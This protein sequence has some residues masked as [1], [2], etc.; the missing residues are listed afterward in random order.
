MTYLWT[1]MVVT[2]GAGPFD[3]FNT[4]IPYPNKYVC[5]EHIS[6]T[7]AQLVAD[8]LAVQMIRCI[9]TDLLSRTV[10]PRPRPKN[11]GEAK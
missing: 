5:G 11:L 7:E 8:G 2:Y 9:E 3:G 10:R 1:I 4:Y 6:A